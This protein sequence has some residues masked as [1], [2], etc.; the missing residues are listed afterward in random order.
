[1]KETKKM[2]LK[3]TEHR[4]EIAFNTTTG[5]EVNP[6]NYERGRYLFLIYFGDEF[7]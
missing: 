5:I 7:V 1:M 3:M 4:R 6:S 2:S